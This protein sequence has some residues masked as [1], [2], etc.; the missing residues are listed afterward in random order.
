MFI[1]FYK[2]LNIIINNLI[3]INSHSQ[4]FVQL[5]IIIVELIDPHNNRKIHFSFAV[6][7]SF[8]PQIRY[9]LPKSKFEPFN[10]GGV[11]TF[12]RKIF[13]RAFYKKLFNS[14]KATFYSAL[15]DLQVNIR[16]IFHI[17][18]ESIFISG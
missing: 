8:S 7:Q 5:N 14:D 16:D 1:L 11:L 12:A 3:I 10:K 18:I 2:F 15:N 17:F 4:T 6:S 13:C 9:M